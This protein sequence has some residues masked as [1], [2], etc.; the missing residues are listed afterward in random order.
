MHCG[1]YAV[2]GCMGANE[3]LPHFAPHTTVALNYNHNPNC[4]W[5]HQAIIMFKGLNHKLN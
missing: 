4:M 2:L 1:M 3:A 5:L